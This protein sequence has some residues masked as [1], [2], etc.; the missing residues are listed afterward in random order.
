SGPAVVPSAPDES[1]LIKAVRYLDEPKMPPK[2]KLSAAQIGALERWVASGA[3]WPSSPARTT[4][5]GGSE[6]APAQPRWW[7]FQPARGEAPRSVK[8]PRPAENEIDDFLQDPLKAG[9][10]TP[11]PPADRRT[12][13]RRATF[14]LTGLPPSPDEVESFLADG[15]SRAFDRV[16]D[17]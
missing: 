5:A 2:Q 14:D 16:V 7:A 15:S 1:R 11:A 6:P 9:G 3:P 12:W 10:I 17:R 13:I 8:R 4:T